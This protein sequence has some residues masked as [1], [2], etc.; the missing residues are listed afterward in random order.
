MYLYSSPAVSAES[1]CEMSVFWEDWKPYIYMIDGE[2]SGPEYHYMKA[3]SDMVN[4]RFNFVE[5]PWSRALLNLKRHDIDMVYGASYK[6]QREQFAIFSL[7]Y[8]YE[9]FVFVSLDKMESNPFSF[10]H[11]LRNGLKAQ[12]TRKIGIIREFYYGEKLEPI[13]TSQSF[14]HK[15]YATRS[16]DELLKMLVH[17]R[18]DGFIVEQIVAESMLE[19]QPYLYIQ[20]IIE[21]KAEPMYFMFSKDLNRNIIKS[22]NQAIQ[23]LNYPSH[24]H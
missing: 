18:I 1:V 10:A 8:R 2:L 9:E 4:C 17:K 11:W 6:K 19:K 12:S 13:L 3:L 15:V 7:P 16:D 21:A 22:I 5:Q 20:H 24:S 14:G 23:A